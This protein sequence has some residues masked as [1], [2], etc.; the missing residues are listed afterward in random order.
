VEANE[1]YDDTA[2]R[3]L[4]EEL[5]ISAR[6]QAIGKLPA[7][8]NTGQEFIVVYQG[9]HDGPF[10]YPSEEITAVEFFPVDIVERW[11]ANKPE[12]F[13]SGFLECWRLFKAK[14]VRPPRS[15]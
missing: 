5:G 10:R 12:D 14:S 15:L 6:L 13:A 3:E 11:M 8:D 7:S 2:A 4:D 1:Q 9:E